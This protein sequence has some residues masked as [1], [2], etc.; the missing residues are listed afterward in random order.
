MRQQ[1]ENTWRPQVRLLQVDW[2]EPWTWSWWSLSW[3]WDENW[4]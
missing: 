1:Q 4:R 2:A 3:L